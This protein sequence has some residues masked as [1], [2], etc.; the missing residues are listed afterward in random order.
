M[1]HTLRLNSSQQKGIISGYASFFDVT[2]HYQDR[3]AKGAFKKTLRAWRLLGKMPKMLWQHDPKY[4]LGVWT[5]LWENE[6]G[7]YVEGRLILGV[8]QA[9]E[10]YLLLKE[11]VL[12]SLS[13]GFRPL[14]A[15]RDKASNSRILLDIDLIEISLVTFGANARATVH[16]V[17][18][19]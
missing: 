1:A 18:T 14:K 12:D 7:L 9:D 3:V 6:R 13:I 4:P 2:D 15:L 11:G 19:Q 17:K 5:S 16:Q 10:A 8:Q